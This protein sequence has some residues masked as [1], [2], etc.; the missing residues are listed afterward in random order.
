MSNQTKHDEV[1]AAIIAAIKRNEEYAG[2]EFYRHD[3]DKALHIKVAIQQAGFKIVRQPKPR[4][5]RDRLAEMS[6]GRVS[7][8]SERD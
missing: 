1:M 5:Q 2:M 6:A 3:Y 8:W 4:E 7:D